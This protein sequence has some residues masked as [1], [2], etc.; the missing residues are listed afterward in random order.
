M[1]NRQSSR[2][3]LTVVLRKDDNS[4]ANTVHR[5]V[6]LAFVGQSDLQVNHINGIKADN[7]LENLEYCTPS[8]NVRHAYTN[9]LTKGE[10]GEKNGSAKLT[11]DD[12]RQI[13]YGYKGWKQKDIAKIYG[14]H[15]AQI[16]KVRLGK[17]WSHI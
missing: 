12:A 5:L 13:K 2:G 14:V 4:R 6:M 7:R 8:E 11:D 17:A 16:S 1:K 9:G 10:K 15:K 3:Y